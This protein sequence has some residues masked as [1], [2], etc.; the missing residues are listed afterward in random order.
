LQGHTKKKKKAPVFLFFYFFA[1]S[2]EAQQFLYLAPLK[3][4]MIANLVSWCG[5]ESWDGAQES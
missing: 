1:I 2:G 4:L 5:E 3:L